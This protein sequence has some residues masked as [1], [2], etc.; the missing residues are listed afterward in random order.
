MAAC[1]PEPVPDGEGLIL[2]PASP[3]EADC[4]PTWYRR[5]RE[6]RLQLT[7]DVVRDL[8]DYDPALEPTAEAVDGP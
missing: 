7:A 1:G 6:G 8:A 3:G 4:E 5:G 2:K